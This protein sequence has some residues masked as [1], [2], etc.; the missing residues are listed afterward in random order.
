MNNTEKV[1]VSYGYVFVKNVHNQKIYYLDGYENS[2]TLSVFEDKVFGKFRFP[3][4][5]S[6]LKGAFDLGR[7]SLPEYLRRIRSYTDK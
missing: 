4:R 2:I 6:N 5:I 1:L 7:E 3:C